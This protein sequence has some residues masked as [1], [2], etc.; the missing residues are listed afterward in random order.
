MEASGKRRVSEEILI[1]LAAGLLAAEA[2]ED[3]GA[4]GMGGERAEGA[5]QLEDGGG[6]AGIVIG[7]VIDDLAGG[8]VARAEVIEVGAE[9]DGLRGERGIGAAEQGEGVVGGGAGGEWDGLEFGGFESEGLELR[10]DIGGGDELV[11]G[12]AAASA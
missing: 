10:D 4:A 2:D 11:V 12:G 5:G 6:A 1:A 9:Q 8:S 3:D 7:S